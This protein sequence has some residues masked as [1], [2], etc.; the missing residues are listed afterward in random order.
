MHRE[1]DTVSLIDPVPAARRTT[2]AGVGFC[3]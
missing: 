2:H 3:G 1:K